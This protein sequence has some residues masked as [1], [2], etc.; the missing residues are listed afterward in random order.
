[1]QGT[2]QYINPKKNAKGEGY[3]TIALEDGE[4]GLIVRD[5][6]FIN[7]LAVGNTYEI[8]ITK[9][10][11]FKNVTD[12]ALISGQPAK[13]E[14]ATKPGGYASEY[15]KRK[16]PVDQAVIGVQ[17]FSKSLIDAYSKVWTVKTDMFTDRQAFNEAVR[18]DTAE[19]LLWLTDIIAGME[20]TG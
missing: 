8:T 1:M 14:D 18:A 15:A 5:P 4:K 20:E 7:Q 11:I 17:A 2:V 3:V 9:Q 6:E 19:Y 16:H 10:G 12:L 13:P